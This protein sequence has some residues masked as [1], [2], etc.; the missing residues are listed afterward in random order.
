MSGGTVEVA[1]DSKG[2]FCDQGMVGV[3]YLSA[4]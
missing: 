2:G 3:Y 4:L 1:Y